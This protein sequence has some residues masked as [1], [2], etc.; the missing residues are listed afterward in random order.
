[1]AN[2]TIPTG[3]HE[4]PFTFLAPRN[5]PPSL[6][7]PLG[8]VNH[9]IRASIKRQGHV[10]T[11]FYKIAGTTGTA[12]VN[13]IV[14][15]SDHTAPQVGTYRPASPDDPPAYSS[16]RREWSGRRRNGQIDWSLQGPASA[17]MSHRIDVLAKIRIAQ[18]YGT[19]DSATVDLVQV[20]KYQAAPDPTVWTYPIRHQVSDDD[21][22][23]SGSDDGFP[24]T[25]M[26]GVSLKQGVAL[27]PVGGSVETHCREKVFFPIFSYQTN[28]SDL[29][30]SNQSPKLS[31]LRQIPV[32]I[33][34]DSLT[35]SP[36][37][38]LYPAMA[39]DFFQPTH[40]R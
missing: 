30:L 24:E 21:D 33:L 36:Y 28:F 25:R 23:A 22:T 8:A 32:Q 13:L 5:L 26:T 18:G 3:V 35:I 29:N 7:A 27:S 1:M 20:E 10:P 14:H 34:Q 9:R 2:A 40:P 6:K 39:L 15:N 12:K 31:L 11:L 37:L 16:N 17:H 19:V 38:F 4:Y